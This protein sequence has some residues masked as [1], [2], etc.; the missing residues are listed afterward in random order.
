M[1]PSGEHALSVWGLKGHPA[2]TAFKQ[3]HRITVISIK[4]VYSDTVT[5]YGVCSLFFFSILAT[6]CS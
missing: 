2:E 3:Q 5:P 6:A 4:K 1:L